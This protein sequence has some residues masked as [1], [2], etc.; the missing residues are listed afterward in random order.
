[1]AGDPTFLDSSVVIAASVAPHPSYE[2]AG[3]FLKGLG[4]GGV[5]TC[6]SPQVCREFVSV[7][8]RQPVAGKTFTTPMALAALDAWLG[9]CVLLAI[10]A[11]VLAARVG[12]S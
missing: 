2:V 8:T 7:L 1:M 3:Q 6:V 5:V 9:S 4:A 11:D 10:N 12:P